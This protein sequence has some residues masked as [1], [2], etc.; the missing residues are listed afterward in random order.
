[1]W[2]TDLLWI[3]FG[4][5]LFLAIRDIFVKKEPPY[6]LAERIIEI[7]YERTPHKDIP[8]FRDSIIYSYKGTG[9]YKDFHFKEIYWLFDSDGNYIPS[10]KFTY[11]FRDSCVFDLTPCTLG[12]VLIRGTLFP[13]GHKIFSFYNLVEIKENTLVFTKFAF[14]DNHEFGPLY[15]IARFDDCLK[16]VDRGLEYDGNIPMALPFSYQSKVN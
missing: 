10:G 7:P 16:Y 8:F 11:I 4:I 14:T 9:R 12:N 6:S 1:M 13:N 5:V 3:I 2:I 15:D